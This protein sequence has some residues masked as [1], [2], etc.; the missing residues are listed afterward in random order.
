MD[1]L[2]AEYKDGIF[3]TRL[4]AGMHQQMQHRLSL[5]LKSGN[6]GAS[7]DNSNK[8]DA[9]LHPLSWKSMQ[10]I[11]RTKYASESELEPRDQDDD[12]DAASKELGGGWNLSYSPIDEEVMTVAHSL[13]D[14]VATSAPSSRHG[15]RES[16][17][18]IPQ[19]VYESRRHSEDDNDCLFDLEL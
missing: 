18:S 2:T 7:D 10:G 15:S 12:R 1:T 16:L 17:L 14:S 8:D 11:V 5:S 13:H 9:D 19:D 6:D 4:M 3:Y